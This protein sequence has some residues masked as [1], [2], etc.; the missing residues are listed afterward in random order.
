MTETATVD[1]PRSRVSRRSPVAGGL[2]G[3]GAELVTLVVLSVVVPRLLGP[4][5]YGQF[6]VVLTVV[7]IGTT[8]LALGGTPLLSRY[9]PAAP[10]A[11]RPALARALGSR[12]AAAR[13]VHLAVLALVAAALVVLRPAAF[14]ADT[15]ALTMV[16]LAVN[17]VATLALQVGLGLGRTG[18]WNARYP[19]QNAVLVAAVVVLHPLAGPAGATWAVV[20][21]ALAGLATGAIA[22]RGVVG[23]GPAA[24]VTVPD[25]ALRFGRQQGVSWALL[26]G[27]LRGGV[28]VVALLVGAGVQTGYA[29]LAIG[30]AA[31]AVH[32]ILQLFVVSLPGLATERVQHAEAVLRR[33]A[34]RLLVVLVPAGAAAAAVLEH[35]VPIVFGGAYAD[36]APVFLPMVALVVLAPAL[37]LL[38]QDAALRTRG[39]AT[40]AGAAAGAV[41][42]VAASAVLVPTHAALGAGIAMLLGV[43]AT[44]LVAGRLLPG[45]LGW[46]VGLA[47][48][49][50][51][52]LVLA[53]GAAA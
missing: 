3:K 17:V 11:E 27:S 50:G 31:A 46:P 44:V 40:L 39:G 52:A 13:L 7:T 35:A 19:V 32:A 14:P 2:L 12:L 1:A 48:G 5:D 28:L 16:A 42:L 49:L 45:A 22:V 8:A 43:A 53:V 10:P 38:L 4:T 34:T 26:Q 51:A 18:P 41:V 15:V 33:L 21:A 36:A 20:V 9:V 37:A 25:G 30:V 29:A 23:A 24:A 47:T 6:A